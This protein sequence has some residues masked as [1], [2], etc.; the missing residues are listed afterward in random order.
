MWGA[1]LGWV[2]L[3]GPAGSLAAGV[4]GCLQGAVGMA[5]G[6]RLGGSA[7]QVFRAVQHAMGQVGVHCAWVG[8]PCC[9]MWQGGAGCSV[10]VVVLWQVVLSHWGNGCMWVASH[11]A[12]W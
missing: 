2:L 5:C 6:C 1:G 8:P 10:L 12:S 3:G 4:G 7:R 11:V 9:V